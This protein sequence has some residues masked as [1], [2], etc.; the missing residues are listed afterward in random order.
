VSDVTVTAVALHFGLILPNYGEDLSAERLAGAAV[1]AEESGFDSGWVTDHLIVP[2][3]LAPVYGSI[4]EALVSLGFLAGRTRRLELGVSAL[5][6]PQRQPLVALKQLTTLDLLS[7]GRIVT[8]VAAGWMEAE[9]ETLRAPFAKR[10]RLLDEWL[11]LAV[12]VFAQ[13]PGRVRYEGALL[14]V[15][16]WLSPAL[17]RPGGPELWVGG[18]S[19]ATL[20]RAA[21]TGVWHP[22]ALRPKELRAMA[23]EFRERRAD[24]RVVL[25]ISAYLSDEPEAGADE[26]G[27]HAISGPPEWMAERLGEYVEAGCDGF[28]LNLDHEREGLEDRVRRF[29]AE[30]LPLVRASSQSTSSR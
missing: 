11:D 4:A 10:G 16:G 8:A 27:R 1:A 7:G 6:V 22:V 21:K 25:R 18:V 14:S 19:R 24:G 30:V 20:R 17:V 5:V 23:A 2:D 15:D 3:E 13:M 9:F 29:G 26:R 12:S 28:V